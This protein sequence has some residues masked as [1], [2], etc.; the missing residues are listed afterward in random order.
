[1][2][3]FILKKRPG[4]SPSPRGSAGRFRVAL[5]GLFLTARCVLSSCQF[6]R[7]APPEEPAPRVIDPKTLPVTAIHADPQEI[8]LDGPGAQWTLLISGQVGERDVDLVGAADVQIV[9]ETI[10]RLQPNGRVRGI[11]DGST[12]VE[13]KFGNLQ[14]SVPV[15]VRNAGVPRQLHFEQ[16]VIPI[17]SRYGCNSSGCHGKA[18][19]QNGFKLSVFGFDPAADYVALAQEGRGRRVF[20]SSPEHSLLLRKATG[21]APHGG[22]T[23][24][25]PD[26]PAYEV[27]RDW[28]AAGLPRGAE[29]LPRVVG[30]SLEPAER[31]VN[32]HASQQ[33]RVLASYSDGHVKD[34]TTLAKFHSNNDA[35]AAV[36]EFGSVTIG[37]IPGS[38]AVMASF[39]GFVDASQFLVPYSGGQS[40]SIPPSANFIDELVNRRLGILNLEPSGPASDGEFLRR[41][42]LD[43]IGTLPTAKEARAFLTDNSSDKRGRLVESLFT[44]SEFA[45]YWALY[46]SDVLRV[47][48]LTLGHASAYAYHQ[49]IRKNIADNVPLDQF[50]AALIAAEG[51]ILESPQ[52]NFYRAVTK[53]GEMASVLSQVF[54]G[55]RIQCAEC[56]HHPYDRWSQDDY[57]GMV[58]YFATVTRKSTG[59]GE[60]IVSGPLSE[61][62]HPRSGQIIRA[63]ALG[64][65]LPA[66]EQVPPA[67]RRE[68]LASWLVSADNP[69]F[70]KNLANR[71]WAR[72]L[73]R[74]LIEPVDDVR[75]TNPPTNP[76]LLEAL[77]K[78]LAEHRFDFR[79]LI[80][81]IVLSDTY[82]RSCSPTP[83]NIDDEQAYSRA[84]LKPIPAE[85]LL[86]SVCQVTG[87]EEKFAGTPRGSRAVQLWDS[88]TSHYFLKLFGRP[89]RQT[90]CECER[91]INPSV[92]QVLHLMNSPEL[93]SKLSHENGTVARA[94]RAIPDNGELVDTLYLTIYSR[95]PTSEERASAVDFLQSQGA[96]R[97]DALE[98]L[99]WGM[100]NSLEFVFNH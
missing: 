28:I 53:P 26:S 37:Q 42:F 98:D 47:D 29:S 64:T 4:N 60:A 74:G 51:P 21:S 72:F 25:E 39:Q 69:W 27:L 80:R 100:L 67:N 49:W 62:R 68:Q 91:Q 18:E 96:A 88:Q 30:I 13:I 15:H 6:V 43:V 81:A 56:H 55:V 79:E 7:S 54:L 17:L 23:R 76:A 99:A 16:D 19:G 3:R 11:R 94:C 22:G 50:A 90:A 34:V 97:R 38:A 8:D 20:I 77:A 2:I 9:D 85:V 52:G 40:V 33:L 82:Q 45:D 65:P 73:G 58:D 44:R 46:W 24:F 59:S 92:A 14:I 48:R 10:A 66:S 78:Y 70:A 87:V 35:L 89:T 32:E 75:D 84:A 93:Q 83:S 71:T 63:H 1:M 86:D 41:V 61:T 5:L 12:S 36:D 57:L 31:I 95:F